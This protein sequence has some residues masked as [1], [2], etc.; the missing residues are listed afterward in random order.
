MKKKICKHSLIFFLLTIIS[1]SLDDGTVKRIESRDHQFCIALGLD[2]IAN[3]NGVDINY[4]DAL[5]AE[6]YW[7]CRII[8]AKNKLR[9]D[10]VIPQ[11]IRHNILINN[12]IADI[13]KNFADS[14]EKWTNSRNSLTD[15]H[16]HK[17]CAAQGYS[18]D[19]LDQT[20]LE[21][22]F[23]CRKK[24]IFDAQIIPPFNQ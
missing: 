12:L 3:E 20:K 18:V 11:D 5:K 22:Y 21:D 6:I 7:R 2:F 16:D 9:N 1:C 4:D 8:L 13:E 23:S 14:Y 17:L 10:S 15:N 24:L 19:T